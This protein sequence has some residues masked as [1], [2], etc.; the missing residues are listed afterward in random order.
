MNFFLHFFRQLFG[1]FH[2][3]AY[4]CPD[5]LTSLI[6]AYENSETSVHRIISIIRIY[7]IVMRRQRLRPERHW[8]YGTIQD[9]E[10]NSTS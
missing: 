5:Y 6:Q 4:I 9:E 10:S 1:L 7:A 8:L 3:T 2:N